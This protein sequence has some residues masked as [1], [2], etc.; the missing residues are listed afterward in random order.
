MVRPAVLDVVASQR[1]DLLGPNAARCLFSLEEK[2]ETGALSVTVADDAVWI[3]GATLFGVGEGDTYELR[4]PGVSEPL[5]DAVVELVSAGRAR[6]AVDALL[7]DPPP[8][9]LLAIPKRVSLGRRPVVVTPPDHPARPAVITA[10]AD[11]PAVRI[12]EPTSVGVMAT[13]EIDDDGIQLLDAAGQP[14]LATRRRL[15][16]GGLRLVKSALATLARA[17][18][19]RE[20]DSGQ[21]DSFLSSDVDLAYARLDPKSGREI[22]IGSGEHLYAGD[23][24]VVRAR[25]RGDDIRYVSVLDVGL[26]GRVA[27]LTNAEP[28]GATVFRRRRACGRGGRNTPTRGY[29]PLLAGRPARARAP[30]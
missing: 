22:P 5:T 2:D 9:G 25:N 15:D 21:G 7:P 13:L 1:P 18:H 23:A 24:V 11:S 27:I 8:P 4:T 6:L 28:S 29:R 3:E 17:T 19:V 12:V 30:P 16:D 10:L 14:L 20:L 26:T